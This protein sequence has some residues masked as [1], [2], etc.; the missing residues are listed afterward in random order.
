VPLDHRAISR[1]SRTIS[2]R[3]VDATRQ[4]TIIRLKASTMKQV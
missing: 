3:M 2:V 4:P 1:A